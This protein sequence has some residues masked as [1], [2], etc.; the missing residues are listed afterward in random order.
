MAFSLARHE[1]AWKSS[2]FSSRH[3]T[4]VA[5]TDPLTILFRKI[6]YT[7]SGSLWTTRVNP[8]H[9][10]FCIC[11]SFCTPTARRKVDPQARARRSTRPSGGDQFPGTAGRKPKWWPGNEGAAAAAQI[12]SARVSIPWD[13]ISRV[14]AAVM[15]ELRKRKQRTEELPLRPRPLSLWLWEKGKAG[16][17]GKCTTAL[18]NRRGT[19]AGGRLS[20]RCPA[21]PPAWGPGRRAPPAVDGLATPA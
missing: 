12:D 17:H 2:P 10:R 16:A 8:A 9:V 4:K 20:P 1:I 13:C 6:Q 11:A 15:L 19:R 7:C 21:R 18:K 5:Q 3:R 14:T